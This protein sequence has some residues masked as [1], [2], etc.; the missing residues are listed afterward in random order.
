MIIIGLHDGHGASACIL[1]NGLPVVAIEEE[2]LTREKGCS[3]YP[4]LAVEWLKSNYPDEMNAIDA[5]AVATKHHDFSFFATKRYPRYSIQDFLDEERLFW[6][7]TLCR[8][9]RLNYLEVM[10]HKVDLQHDHYPLMTIKDR[11]N[12]SEIQNMRAHFISEDLCIQEKKIIFVDHHT[13]HAHHAY[14]SSPLRNNCLIITMDGSGDGLNCTVSDIGS[15]GGLRKLYSTDLCNIGRVYQ[16]ITLLSGMKPAEHEYKVMGLAAYTKDQYISGPLEV[17]RQTY[18]VDGLN[19]KINNPIKNHYQYF[20]K[21]LEGFRFDAIAGALQKWTE[22]L[23][24]QFVENWVEETGHRN[25]VFSGGVALNIKACKRLSELNCVDDIFVS[26][27]GGDESTSIG[28]AQYVYCQRNNPDDL[29]QIT[30][31]YLSAGYTD[32]DVEEALSHSFV[33]ENFLITKEVSNHDI[34]KILSNGYV[35]GLI[36]GKMEFGP[37]ALGH[38]SLLADPRSKNVVAKINE[39]IKNRDFWMPFTPSILEEYADKYLINPKKLKSPY[40]TMAFDT[41]TQAKID[42]AAAI[43]AYDET[44]RPQIV[45]KEYSPN[46]YLLLKAFEKETG[47]GGLLNTSFNIHGKPIV[48]KP[49]D[50]IEEVLMHDLVDLKYVVID[51]IL[52]TKIN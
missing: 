46:Y 7:P 29:V 31:P 34:A 17:F 35:V 24:S 4:K 23:L 45:T 22:E 13:C 2:R 50:I 47:V 27:A 30:F 41:T 19:F 28:A 43:H 37:R 11:K 39:T 21:R 48:H 44:V 1:K 51:N 25:V 3:G 16:F 49:I 52:L 14:F 12:K 20:R 36:Y 9:E 5:V 33:K 10:S 32:K 26:L 42:L 6:V 8:D 40:M 38:R 18:F 15:G